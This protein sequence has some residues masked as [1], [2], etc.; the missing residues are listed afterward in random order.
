[1]HTNHHPAEMRFRVSIIVIVPSHNNGWPTRLPFLRQHAIPDLVSL[2][3]QF[4]VSH[5]GS[6]S[7]PRLHP[8]HLKHSFRHVG[9]P[10]SQKAEPLLP[11]NVRM[12]AHS[13]SLRIRGGAALW[14][15]LCVKFCEAGAVAEPGAKDLDGRA[16]WSE[17]ELR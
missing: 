5:K 17:L 10:A 11:H 8:S 6:R 7:A 15:L 14:T 4:Q 12:V 1:M 9:S 16:G 3:S 2:T 13:G